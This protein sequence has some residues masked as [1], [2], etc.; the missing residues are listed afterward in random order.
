MCIIKNFPHSADSNVKLHIGS[1]K[2]ARNEQVCSH[3]SLTGSKFS[4]A[5]LELFL[6]PSDC[7]CAPIGG[8]LQ[9]FDAA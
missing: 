1:P 6:H 2:M 7:S 5:T 8:L 4:K 3:Q 9:F